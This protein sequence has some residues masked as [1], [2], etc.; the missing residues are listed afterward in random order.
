[1]KSLFVELPIPVSDD[2]P[3]GYRLILAYAK[4]DKVVIPIS[5]PIP[6]ET[7]HNCDWEGCTSVSH[8]ASFSIKQK[9]EAEKL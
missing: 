1:M 6:D 5:G 4:G 9:Y 3:E 8:V 2:V 7:P